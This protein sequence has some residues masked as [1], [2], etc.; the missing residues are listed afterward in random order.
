TAAS[1]R[2][3]CP[4]IG[5]AEMTS[6]DSSMVTS[7]TTEPEICAALASGGYAGST[8]RVA[9]ACNTPPDFLIIFGTSAGS[10]DCCCRALTATP[11]T[12][13]TAVINDVDIAP[14][15][16][17]FF[18][19]ISVLLSHPKVVGASPVQSLRTS[20][21]Y[22]SHGPGREHRDRQINAR[23]SFRFSVY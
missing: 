9:E 3:G 8:R 12:S 23:R 21:S 18:V 19:L 7:T 15:I 16:A 17:R 1:F 4:D 6:P 5:F 11:V 2:S 20:H 10:W 14:A 22:T 13:Q